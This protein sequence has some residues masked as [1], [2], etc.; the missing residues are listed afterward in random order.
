[1][2]RIKQPM[3]YPDWLTVID[4]RPHYKR[5]DVAKRNKATSRHNIDELMAVWQ[6]LKDTN[7]WGNLRTDTELAKRYNKYLREQKRKQI[8]VAAITKMR[9]QN[10]TK[11]DPFSD[12]RHE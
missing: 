1:M 6:Y 3:Q 2:P 11:Q 4:L 8:T 12:P 10:E 7:G 9:I 5:A